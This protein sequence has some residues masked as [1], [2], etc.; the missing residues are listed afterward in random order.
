MN[1]MFLTLFFLGLIY[2]FTVHYFIP[3]RKI[4]TL[5]A[6]FRAKGYRVYIYP[7]RPF[8]SAFFTQVAKDVAKGDA[9]KLLKE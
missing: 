1:E 2:L 4:Q 9:Q 5:A 8:L 6:K 3:K 7:F